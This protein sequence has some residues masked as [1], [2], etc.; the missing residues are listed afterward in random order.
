MPHDPK[1]FHRPSPLTSYAKPARG[2]S[3]SLNPNW[4]GYAPIL[5]DAGSFVYAGT[6]SFSVLTPRF[7]VSLLVTDQ[8]SCKKNSYALDRTSPCVM[9]P[10]RGDAAL[11][12]T[13]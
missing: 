2:A 8:L 9:K 7:N 10:W 5:L 13:W 1:A 12:V 4:I 11:L 3:L 6:F